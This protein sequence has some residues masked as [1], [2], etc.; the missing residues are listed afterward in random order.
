MPKA[1]RK[2]SKKTSRKADT[3]ASPRTRSQFNPR[4]RITNAITRDLT[5]IERARGFLQAATLSEQW[6]TSMSQRALLLE[7]HHTTH[8]EGTQLTLEQSEKLLAGKQVHGVSRD[9]RLELLNYREAFELVARYILSDSPITETLI[10]EIHRLLVVGV[11]G[12]EARPG[13]YRRVQNL[14]ANT[15]TGRI[16]YTP[17]PADDVPELMRQLV[18]W[19]NTETDV[20]P[21]LMSGLAQFQLVHIH[22]FVDGNGR[23]SRL[24]STLCLYRTGYDFKR[25]F[26]LSEFYDRDRGA[27][28]HAIQHVRD[29]GMNCT[30]WLEYYCHGL[31]SQMN[32]TVDR[33]RKVIRTDVLAREHDLNER[34]VFVLQSL[35]DGMRMRISDMESTFP[36][37]NR[38]TL[39]R[40][41]KRLA[42]LAIIEY[43]AA[44]AT[45]PNREYSLREL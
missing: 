30:G 29:S 34:Q 11:R 14:V 17:P 21:V 23:T 10:R 45:D 16:I 15:E 36:R 19:L 43:S 5:T 32:E 12:G 24:L 26:T 44:S 1:T 31:A 35:M 4:F 37:V 2:I 27:Y 42:D 40:D 3:N 13:E 8:I 18:E 7:A 6:V 25:L 33:G 9:D 20:H 22:P 38:R 28:Y 39:Q 41:L